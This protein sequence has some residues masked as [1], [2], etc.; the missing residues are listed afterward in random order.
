MVTSVAYNGIDT[1]V[2]VVGYDTNLV[3]YPTTLYSKD[4]SLTWQKGTNIFSGGNTYI[5]YGSGTSVAYNGIDT[6]VAIGIVNDRS[7]VA[8]SKDG[9]NWTMGTGIEVS[10]QGFPSDVFLSLKIFTLK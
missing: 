9:I 5:D 6:W 8:Y 7:V 3:G 2:A 4:G 10:Y 1:W